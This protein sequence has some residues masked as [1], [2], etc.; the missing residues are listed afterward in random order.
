LG[1][2]TDE[3][4]TQYVAER[5]VVELSCDNIKALQDLVEEI[6]EKISGNDITLKK[7]F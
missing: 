2:S 7:Y 3:P 1:R 6:K 4:E 5:S